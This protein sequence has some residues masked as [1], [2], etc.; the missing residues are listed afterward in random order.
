MLER[1][2]KPSPP[3][4]STRD[5]VLEEPL[6]HVC[7]NLILDWVLYESGEQT[8][9]LFFVEYSPPGPLRP[10]AVEITIWPS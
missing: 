3:P 6:V 9:A 7:T 4:F 8:L 10:D 5:P 1:L 2:E